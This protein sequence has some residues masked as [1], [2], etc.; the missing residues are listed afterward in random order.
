MKTLRG[1]PPKGAFP[2]G[3]VKIGRLQL[4]NLGSLWFKR[5]YLLGD[6]Q[7]GGTTIPEVTK[8]I[9]DSLKYVEC[10]DEDITIK[11][12]FS[13][14]N[15]REPLISMGNKLETYQSL[16]N[17]LKDCSVDDVIQFLKGEYDINDL[18]NGCNK[19]VYMRLL[20]VIVCV[21]EVG[22]G[23]SDAPSCLLEL[24]EKEIIW[25]KAFRRF[26]P[27][28]KSRVDDS[29]DWSNDMELSKRWNWQ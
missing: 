28:L 6:D 2:K 21:A 23:M 20:V 4:I 26:P 27:V 10:G 15:W 22:R 25:N 7:I 5:V 13:M 18:G 16:A 9:N 12:G 29:R 17:K 11:A 3:Y 24:L 1:K 14:N 8:Q 19:G